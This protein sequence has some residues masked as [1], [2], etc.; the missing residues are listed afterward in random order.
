MKQRAGCTVSFVDFF[1]KM[2]KI[3]KKN[4]QNFEKNTNNLRNKK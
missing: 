4:D 1:E 2:V 3:S